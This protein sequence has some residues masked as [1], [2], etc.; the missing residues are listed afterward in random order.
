MFALRFI[1]LLFLVCYSWSMGQIPSNQLNAFGTFVSLLFFL[2]APALYLLP[3]Y[4]A[5]K[6]KHPNMAA[7]AL[8]NVFLG[9]SL[10][11]WV[12]ATVWAFKTTEPTTVVVQDDTSRHRWLESRPPGNPVPVPQS[13]VASVS[14]AD[15]IR[16]LADLR[17]QGLLTAEEFQ[18]Q[19]ALALRGAQTRQG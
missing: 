5:W 11:G 19:K 12:V 18:A 16:K 8:V 1:V 4:E 2:A 6:R 15:E 7:I 10:F 9:W 13:P 3:T 14:V 17:D